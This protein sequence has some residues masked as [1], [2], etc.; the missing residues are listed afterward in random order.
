[1]PSG[2]T[3]ATPMVNRGREV[4]LGQNVV[5]IKGNHKGLKGI[6]KDLNGPLARVELHSR[7][8]TITIERNKLGVEDRNSKELKTLEQWERDRIATKKNNS[9]GHAN[10]NHTPLSQRTPSG[11]TPAPASGYGG[12]SSGK[13]VSLRFRAACPMSMPGLLPLT[14]FL[15]CLFRTPMHRMGGATP[16]GGGFGGATPFGAGGATPYNSGKTPA[17]GGTG[18]SFAVRTQ[19][20]C[21][22]D[23]IAY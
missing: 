11:Y 23:I 7:M 19:H 9:I 3:G 15:S 5:V 12:Y 21:S 22:V 20:A 16:F 4:A 6:I 13:Y 2:M 8:R 14:C 18:D 17:Y 1:M 10:T